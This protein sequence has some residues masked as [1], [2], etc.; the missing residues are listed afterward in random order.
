ML[1]QQLQ[2]LVFAFYV[3][4]IFML[5]ILYFTYIF[6]FYA[7]SYYFSDLASNSLRHFLTTTWLPY[8]QLCAT[9]YSIF[10]PKLTRSLVTRNKHECTV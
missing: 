8:S 4:N 10:E 2:K 6:F 1:D 3:I 7:T 5:Y 9:F